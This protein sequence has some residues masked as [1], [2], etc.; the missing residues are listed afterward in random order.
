MTD[1]ELIRNLGGPTVLAARLKF[2]KGGVQR[3]ANWMTR[4]IPARVKL[5]HPDLFPHKSLRAK[6]KVKEAA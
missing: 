4:G 3:V 2:K 5:D 1:A 6:R